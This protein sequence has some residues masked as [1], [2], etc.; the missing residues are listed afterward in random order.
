[1][2]DYS[3]SKIKI[4]SLIEHSILWQT[5]LFVLARGLEL[6][7]LHQ[8]LL[9]VLANNTWSS[10]ERTLPSTRTH[11]FGWASLQLELLDFQLTLNPHTVPGSW[12][13]R[14]VLFS[15]SFSDISY[16]SRKKHTWVPWLLAKQ[17]KTY[18]CASPAHRPG[19]YLRWRKGESHNWYI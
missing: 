17:C 14:L 13:T 12:V 2:F 19:V 18:N 9:V 3:W 6:T 5:L 10:L 1:M 8:P 15:C 11:L 7:L 4:G 16:G